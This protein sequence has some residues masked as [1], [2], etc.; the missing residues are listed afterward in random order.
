[1]TIKHPFARRRLG[2][3]AVDTLTCRNFGSGVE[4]IAIHR[5]S[6]QR[7]AAASRLLLKHVALRVHKADRSALFGDHEPQC[8]GC[9]ADTVFFVRDSEPVEA[10]R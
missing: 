5:F 4:H 8:V 2:P 1:M 10:G 9:D 3:R 6:D 7:L